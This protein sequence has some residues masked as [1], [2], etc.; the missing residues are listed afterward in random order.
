MSDYKR[1]C[2]NHYK[3]IENYELAL[4][5]NF[6][7][8]H[9]HHRN[10]EEFSKEWLIQNNM[11]YDREDP[12][13]FRFVPLKKEMSEKYGIPSHNTIHHSGKNCFFTTYN[14]IRDVSGENNPMYGKHLSEEAKKNL[15]KIASQRKHN[16]ET[17]IKIGNSLRGQTRSVFGKKFIE[18]YGIENKNNILYLREYRF[19]HKHGHC[20]WEV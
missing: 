10:G 16:E 3:E 18:H 9:C 11:Y 5:D 6:V 7:G 15:S 17:K 12:H 20:S 13:E 2:P 19:Y 8:W 14:K 1:F 4:K